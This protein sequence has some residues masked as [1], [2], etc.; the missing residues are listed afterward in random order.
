MAKVR[1]IMRWLAAQQLDEVMNIECTDKDT[2]L[3]KLQTEA[4]T[5]IFL[6]MCQ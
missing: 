2:T 3:A 5:N 1:V 4:N 6:E